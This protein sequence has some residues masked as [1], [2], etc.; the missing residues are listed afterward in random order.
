MEFVFVSSYAQQAI[1]QTIA[2][3]R[4]GRITVSSELG[5]GSCFQVYLLIFRKD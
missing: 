4:S 5:V 1:A 2:R 3:A